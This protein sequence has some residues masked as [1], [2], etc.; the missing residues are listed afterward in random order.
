ME[1]TSSVSSGAN[2]TPG[3]AS[4][5]TAAPET[6]EVETYEQSQDDGSKT[7]SFGSDKKAQAKSQKP[8]AKD[9][10]AAGQKETQAEKAARK[11]AESDLDAVVTVKINGQV[12]EMSVREL[13]KVKQLEEASYEK[14]KQAAETEKRAKNLFKLFETDLDAFARETGLDVDKIA[15]ERLA[16]KYELMQMTPEQRRV[17]E[18]EKQLKEREQY[19]LSTKS[20]VISKIKEVMG[21]EAPEGLE[22][23]PKEQL[24]QFYQAKIQESQKVMGDLERELLD[25]WKESGLPKNKYFGSWMAAVMHSHEKRTKEPL[26]ATEAASIVKRDFVN[27]VKEVV[28]QMDAQAIQ[29]FLGKDTVQKLRDF[30]IQRVTGKAASKVGS[31]KSPAIAASPKKPMNEHEW[32]DHI[33]KMKL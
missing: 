24:E 8:Q 6:N 33:R 23:Y 15:E 5:E 14:M 20:E 11:L 25:A 1:S 9:P 2:A 4:T 7:E 13:Q 16:R 29:D 18:L 27:C 28:S 10:K 31:T 17:M 30:D 19:E 26:Q 21:A 22:K 32:R 3:A 12:K